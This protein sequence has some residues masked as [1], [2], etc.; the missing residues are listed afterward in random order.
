MSGFVPSSA[1]FEMKFAAVNNA[2]VTTTSGQQELVP[3]VHPTFCEWS[4][5]FVLYI[6]LAFQSNIGLCTYKLVDGDYS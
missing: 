2:F 4:A 1:A 3:S 6:K 5:C